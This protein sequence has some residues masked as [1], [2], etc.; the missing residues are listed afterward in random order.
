MKCKRTMR[1]GGALAFLVGGWL[2]AAMSPVMAQSIAIFQQG[3]S[4]GLGAFSSAGTVRTGS[5][6]AVMQ[7]SLL[8]ADGAITS[9]AVSTQGYGNLTVA[10]DRVTANLET[11]ALA[12]DGGYFEYAVNG[13]SFNRLEATTT[14][15][16][17]RVQFSLPAAANNA[18]VTLRFRVNA[19]ASDETYTVDN[20]VISGSLIG[21]GGVATPPPVGEFSTFESGHVRPMALSADGTRLYVVNTPD[22]RLEVFDVTGAAPSLRESIPV[23][24]EPVAVAIAPDGRVWVVN[25]LSD[26]VSIV[27]VNSF[28]ARVVNT[29]LVGDEPRD[30]VFAGPG[31]RWAFITAAHRGQNVRFNPELTKPGIGRAD[32][33]VYDAAS[34]GTAM[35]G[36]PATVLNMFGDT[37]RG[38]AR[39]PDGSRV[40]TAVFNSGNRTT[41]VRGGPQNVLEKSGPTTAAD[42]SKAP[43]TSL[44]VQKNAK[45]DWVDA[46]DPKSGAAPKTWN[47]HVRLDLPDHD[48]FTIDTTTSVP[49]VIDRVSGV[50]T[51]LFN[52][53]VNPANGKVYVS[54]QEARNVVRF[55]GPG[56][57]SSTVNG[58]FV[59]SRVTV[60]DGRTVQPRHL[61]KHIRSYGQPLGTAAENAAAVAIPLEMA[62][63]PD[64]GTMYLV[65]MG[66]NKIARYVTAQLESDTFVPSTSQQL[67]LSGGLPTGIVLD[68]PRG[69]AFVTTRQD[70]GV[71]VVN[72][73]SFSEV[74]HVKLANPE[75]ADVVKGRRFMYDATYTSSRGDSSCAACHVFGDMD[76]LAWDLGNPDDV[77]AKNNNTYNRFVLNVLRTTKNFHPMKGPM[78]TQSFRGMAGNGPLHWRGDRQGVSTG[79]TLEERAFKDFSVAF[80]GLLGRAAPLSDEEMTAFA[81]FALKLQYPPNPVT[82]LDGSFSG[83]QAQGQTFYMTKNADALTTC[84]GCHAL[85]P[86]KGQFGTDGTMAFEGFAITEN[87]KI[88]HLRNMYQKVGFFAENEPE[89]P[90]VGEQVKGF[91]YAFDGAL[92][93]IDQFLSAAVFFPVNATERKQLQE[94]VLAF[95]SDLHPIVGQQLTVTPTNASQADVS[96]RLSLLLQRA[97]VTSPRPEC[98]LIAKGVLGGAARGWVLSRASGTFASDRRSEPAWSLSQ[99]LSQARTAGAPL[100]FTCTPPGNGTRLGIDR[101]ADGRFDRD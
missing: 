21:T 79:A 56:I 46:G 63:S 93:T 7:A 44:I 41:V 51:T 60:I 31:N 83:M 23:G 22:A 57:N 55:E 100:T 68:A 52:L 86:L 75:P 96:A 67:V 50:G 80:P 37:L 5:T 69:R 19:D 18:S 13:G 87:F 61:N 76:Q 34:P 101:N 48:V 92:G 91:G 64:G 15:T 49:T 2:C 40:Y 12:F 1:P 82:N 70:N 89:K 95:P 11:S 54:N 9:R 38:L 59:E 88:P 94:F 39:S 10:F 4:G 84:N 97:M 43:A 28:P 27:D 90:Y 30:I 24:L 33:W 45:G 29:L 98:E 74:A 81:R 58:N 6:G 62:V 85:D 72:T 78:T 71:S 14:T 53:A 26:S 32:V 8:G 77:R 3:F 65:S 17:G 36:T 47:Q 73:G 16:R 42:G 35:G 25:H 66:T 20:V 99:L